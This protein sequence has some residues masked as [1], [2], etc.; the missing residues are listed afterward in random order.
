MTTS[1]RVLVWIGAIGFL[2]LALLLAAAHEWWGT[3][4]PGTFGNRESAGY[5]LAFGLPLTLALWLRGREMWPNVIAAAWVFLLGLIAAT[6]N[7]G[8]YAWCGLGAAG[9][10][11]W[12]IRDARSE[13]INIGMIGFAVTLLFFYFSEVMDKLGRSA[14]L[15]GLGV[16]F[17]AGGWALERMRRRWVAQ[18]RS[19]A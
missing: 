3:T 9:M 12:G 8:V 14:S 16:L 4:V 7:V 1:R 5:T 6:H 15:I 19:I 2:P 10:V 11:A 18:A 13:R 17:L